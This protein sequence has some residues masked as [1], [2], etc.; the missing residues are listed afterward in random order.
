MKQS[1]QIK[2]QC[3]CSNVFYIYPYRKETA[4]YCS[5]KCLRKYRLYSQNKGKKSIK[6]SLAK[7]GALNPNFGKHWSEEH[8]AKLMPKLNAFA[9]TRHVSKEHKKAVKKL[10]ELKRRI[11]KHSLGGSFTIDQWDKKKQEF[12]FKCPSCKRTEIELLNTYKIGLTID[13]IIPLSKWEEYTRKFP[14]EYKCGDIENIQP[15]CIKCNGKKNNREI[16]HYNPN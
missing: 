15:L 7:M 13:H 5:I 14:K 4:K 2:K 10:L 1:K 12:Q 3:P 9:K 16:T 6:G 11:L 8:R